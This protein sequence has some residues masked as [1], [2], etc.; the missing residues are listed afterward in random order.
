MAHPAQVSRM[1]DA[2]QRLCF[3]AA[4]AALHNTRGMA[5]LMCW[6]RCR[7]ASTFD[8]S[9]RGLGGCP[10]PGQRQHLQRR[11]YPHAAGRDGYDTGIALD[12]LLDVVF[13]N[14]RTSS[15][16]MCPVRSLKPGVSASCTRR[17][18]MWPTCVNGLP[19]V[20]ADCPP[21]PPGAD[22]H[23]TR[24]PASTSPACWA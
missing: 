7:A 4:D 10:R 14:R 6:L 17:R 18:P 21:R 23:R 15:A 20:R 2:L 3:T 22:H 5:W 19:G 16:T 13:G 9:A 24:P 8:G 12:R 11:R 1:V